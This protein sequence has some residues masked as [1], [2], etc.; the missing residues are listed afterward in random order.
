MDTRISLLLENISWDQGTKEQSPC[1]SMH[2]S[3]TFIPK[4]AHVGPKETCPELQDGVQWRHKATP[5]GTTGWPK[6]E[7]FQ[8]ITHLY[9]T[10]ASVPNF[11]ASRFYK[12]D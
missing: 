7:G 3:N 6:G 11:I 8:A 4:A 1:R 10:A 12:E 2:K 5:A 9:L